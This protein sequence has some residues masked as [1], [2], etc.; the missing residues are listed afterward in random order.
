MK[1]SEA[2]RGRHSWDVGTLFAKQVHI[3]MIAEQCDFRPLRA[4][5][6]I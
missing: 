4:S 2:E 5:S 1:R 6:G 3:T